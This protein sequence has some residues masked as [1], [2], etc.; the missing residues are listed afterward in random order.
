[1]RR[2]VVFALAAIAAPLC[3]QTP[4]IEGNWKSEDGKA[5]IRIAPCGTGMCGRVVELLEPS[6]P[7]GAHD[8]NNPDAAKRARSLLGLRVFWEL[9]PQGQRFEGKGYS[10]RKGRYFDAQVWRDGDRLRVRGCVKLICQEQTL[11]PG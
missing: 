11:R 10:P 4:S 2:L 5:V 8:V 1:M 3:A 7:G 9:T 6:P